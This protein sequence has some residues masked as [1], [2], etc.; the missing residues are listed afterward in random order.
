MKAAVFRGNRVNCVRERVVGLALL[1]VGLLTSVAEGA[2]W[3]GEDPEPQFDRAAQNLVG[4]AVKKQ[5]LPKN[6]VRFRR[7]FDLPTGQ[8]VSAQARVCGLGFYELWAN[9]SPADPMRRLAPNWSNPDDR[10]LFD[11]YD[12]TSRLVAGEKN[13][14]GLWLAAGYSD[15]F[16]RWGWRWLKPKRAWLELD[17]TYADGRQTQIATDGSW[18]WTDETPIRTA[19]IYGGECYDASAEDPDW[20]TARKGTAHWRKVREFKDDGLR[21]VENMGAPVRLRDPREPVEVISLGGDRWILDF[22]QNRAG[23]VGFD[24]ELPKGSRVTISCAEE[25]AADRKSLDVRTLRGARQADEYVFAGRRGGERYLPRFTYHGFRYAEV[26]GVP[27]AQM[28]KERFRSWAVTADVEDTASFR[29]SDVTLNWLFNAAYWSMRSNLVG[30]PSDCPMRNERT[31]CLMDSNCFEDT[32]CLFFDMRDFYAKWLGDAVRYQ[33]GVDPLVGD[34]DNPD[35]SGEPMLLAERLLTHYAATNAVRREYVDLR[36]LMDGFLSRSPSNVWQVGFGDWCPPGG[37]SWKDYHSSVGLVNTLFLGD[38]CRAMS[39]VA[40]AVGEEG[41]AV[42]YAA[43]HAVCRQAFR[44]TFYDPMRKTFGDGK[45]TDLAMPLV[46]GLVDEADRPAVAARLAERIRTVDLGHFGTGIYGTR[47]LG[48]ALLENGLED[49]WLQVVKARGEPGFEY[50]REKGATTTW[51]QWHWAGGM[52]S[53]NHA[54]K[55]GAA[56]CLLTHLAGIRCQG[57]GRRAVRIQP[58]FPGKLAWVEARLKTSCGWLAVSWKRS[59][60]KIVVETTVP[61]GLVATLALPNRPDERLSSGL[62]SHT[63]EMDRRLGGQ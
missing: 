22:G 1:A 50:M 19:T 24:L 6:T 57:D 60:G 58:V 17:V 14:L 27:S 36:K 44:E 46:F 41:D 29:S 52:N 25:I 55:S 13:V 42:R 31:P 34:N 51:E 37:K 45:Q 56:A 48:D 40:R 49:L 5:I 63:C 7:A 61:A 30:Y 16:F 38:C 54:M 18:K 3:I 33:E 28:K 4:R 10:V 39:R 43:R 35:W 32:A 23:L 47:Y 26:A 2:C 9:G 53:H 15:D 12:L 62:S 11:V 59:G 8:I 20:A 21:L